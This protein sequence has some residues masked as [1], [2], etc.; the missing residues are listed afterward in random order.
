MMD[1][2]NKCSRCHGLKPCS[3]FVGKKAPVVKTCIRCRSNKPKP[4]REKNKQ[5]ND[6]R[7]L[8]FPEHDRRDRRDYMYNYYRMRKE[9]KEIEKMRI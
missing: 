2:K 5:Y 9:K 8:K 7:R 4:T 6:A 1:R 3:D